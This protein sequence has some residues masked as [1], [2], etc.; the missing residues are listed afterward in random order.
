MKNSNFEVMGSWKVQVII[1]RFANRHGVGPVKMGGATCATPTEGGF[2]NR[3]GSA[4]SPVLG[5]QGM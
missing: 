1:S 2:E 4:N 3:G 5:V